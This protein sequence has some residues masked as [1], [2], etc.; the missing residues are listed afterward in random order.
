MVMNKRNDKISII[1]PVY[2]TEKY[3]K[4]CVDSLRNQTYQNLEIILVDDGSLD[5]SGRLCDEFAKE[6]ARVKVIHKENGGL[7][8]AWKKG[9]EVSSGEYLN[10]IDS[11]DFVELTM[12]EEMAKHLTGEEREIVASD[13]VIEREDGSRQYVWQKLSP[14]EYTGAALKEKVIPNLLGK[15]SRYVTIS[16]CMKLI[17][18]RLITENCKYSDPA[19]V[20]GEDATI[21]LPALIDCRRLYVMDHKAYYHYRH[22]NG[23]MAHKYDENLYKNI[24]LLQQTAFRIVNDKF[25]GEEL[26]ERRKQVDQ[27]TVFWMMLVLKNEARGNPKHYRKN[28]LSICKSAKI[29]SLIRETPVTVEQNANKLLYLV[30]KHPNHITVSLLRVA[31]IWYYRKQ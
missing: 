22:L 8:S 3:I 30:M 15:E 18:R 29:K 23:S 26:S 31:M 11:D 20:M 4:K 1:V 6:D 17:S 27:E 19:A 13:Y 24:Q 16:R 14:G 2:N 28:I 9:V 10:F 7:V 21:M 25:T 12:I 5:G